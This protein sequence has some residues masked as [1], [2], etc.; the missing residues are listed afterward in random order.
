[1]E[2]AVPGLKEI[3]Y[4]T[5]SGPQAVLQLLDMLA[6]GDPAQI[7][8]VINKWKTVEQ[9]LDAYNGSTNATGGT[10]FNG[11][12]SGLLQGTP[13][14]Q[15]Q[16]A[17]RYSQRAGDV[18]QYAMDLMNGISYNG[19]SGQ[20]DVVSALTTVRDALQQAQETGVEL[21]NEL[22]PETGSLPSGDPIWTVVSCQQIVDLANQ[23]VNQYHAQVLQM[24][25][26][27]SQ[28]MI[29]GGLRRNLPKYTFQLPDQAT[30]EIAVQ[31]GRFTSSLQTGKPSTAE[32]SGTVTVTQP[33]YVT[34]PAVSPKKVLQ[35]E[36]LTAH[37]LYPY[38]NEGVRFAAAT[39]LNALADQYARAAAQFPQPADPSKLP[40]GVGGTGTNGGGYGAPPVAA[41]GGVSPSVTNGV[42]GP[43]RS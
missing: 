36:G 26:N 32:V 8:D 3:D 40:K 1:V 42:N 20:N 41:T 7:T 34:K 24:L 18:S 39:A 19:A 38:A 31:L 35:I 23:M 25:D 17:E 29:A 27:P 11:T 22:V 9:E 10:S 14:W 30:V 43:K 12:V 2:S 15:G 13:P 16:S 6:L 33:S 28:I 4:N 5:Y 21:T 37:D